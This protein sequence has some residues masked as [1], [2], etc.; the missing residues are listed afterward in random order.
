ME[1]KELNSKKGVAGLNILL[2]LIAMLF[3]IGIII[4]VFTIAGSKL[5]TAVATTETVSGVVQTSVAFTDAGT[6]LTT[7]SGAIDGAISSITSA[8]NDSVTLASGNYTTSG[9]VLY[10]TATSEYNGTTV[11]NVTYVYTHGGEA[12]ATINATYTSLDDTTDWFPTF[13]VLGAMVVLILLVV[14]II[15]SIR[16]S[17]ITQGA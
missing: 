11:D 4:M 8:V 2:S 3:M 10:A 1:Y 9:C 15:N 14:I 12:G 17:G 16:S 5:R 7:C 6:T 13:I